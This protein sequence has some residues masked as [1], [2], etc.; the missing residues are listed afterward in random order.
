MR[1]WPYSAK[2]ISALRQETLLNLPGTHAERIKAMRAKGI[3]IEDG[4]ND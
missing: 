3:T 1:N 2:E 4:M